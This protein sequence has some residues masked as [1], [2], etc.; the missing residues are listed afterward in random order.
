MYRGFC[1]KRRESKRD[2][3]EDQDPGPCIQIIETLRQYATDNPDTTSLPSSLHSSH[4]NF[5]PGDEDFL[6]DGMTLVSHYAKN[7][8]QTEF[9][10]AEPP[11]PMNVEQIISENED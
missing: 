4:G 6:P 7:F 2:R 3:N 9:D 5:I 10:N 11:I 1:P 8:L